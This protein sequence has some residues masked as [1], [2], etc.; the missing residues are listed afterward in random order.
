MASKKIY[1]C[2][3]CGGDL[4]PIPGVNLGR[5]D[6]CGTTQPVPQVTDDQKVLL[7]NRANQYR[8]SH[9]YKLAITE[10]ENILKDDPNDPDVYWNIALCRHEIEYVQ[11]PTSFRM[12]PTCNRIVSRSIL[13]EPDYHKALELSDVTSRSM[14][15]VEAKT[16]DQIE[17]KTREVYSTEKP[18]DVF[19]CYKEKNPKGGRTEDSVIAEHIYDSLKSDYRVFFSMISLS[20]KLGAEY[21]PYIYHALQTAKVMILVS[22]DVEHVKSIWLENEWSR[23]LKVMEENHSK[24]LVIAYKDMNP[25]DLP[26][27]LSHMQGLDIGKIGGMEDL[28]RGIRSIVGEKKTPAAESGVVAAGI[29]PADALYA[30]GQTNLRLGEWDAADSCFEDMTSYYPGDWRGWWGM[31][32]IYTRGL[33]DTGAY[34]DDPNPVRNAFRNAKMTAPEMA[35]KEPQDLYSS[36]LQ[37]VSE[38]QYQ[39]EVKRVKDHISKIEKENK[40]LH[41]NSVEIDRKIK[42]L[43]D[44][45]ATNKSGTRPDFGIDDSIRQLKGVR[46]NNLFYVVVS[47]IGACM[48]LGLLLMITTGA[49]TQESMYNVVL[50]LLLIIMAI[51]GGMIG[52][53]WGVIGG[54][55]LWYFIGRMIPES[56]IP[57]FVMILIGL[58]LI[59]CMSK[60]IRNASNRSKKKKEILNWEGRRAEEKAAIDAWYRSYDIEAGKRRQDIQNNQN[61]IRHNQKRIGQ[62]M[63]YIERKAEIQQFFHQEECKAANIE[64]PDNQVFAQQRRSIMGS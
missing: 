4:V 34:M 46:S 11:D 15:E 22:T 2:K 8:R 50:I 1:E 49:I 32:L 9:D 35:I 62:F 26:Y 30:N 52:G 18:Y 31:V 38:L 37:K 64:V 41:D 27:Q 21:E 61:A 33:R 43:Y 48:G 57:V 55:V 51:I 3:I 42:E 58:F 44:D 17:R 60:L 10:F 29:L 39:E 40:N 47:V 5:C 25:G 13:D 24:R 45:R 7:Y 63:A 6:S 54:I 14:Y 56:F 59:Y 36:Y 19:I 12:V 20:D 23:Y 16:I 28:L 53:F